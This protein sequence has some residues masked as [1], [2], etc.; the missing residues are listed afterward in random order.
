MN[1]VV[2]TSVFSTFTLWE[3]FSVFIFSFLRAHKNAKQTIF[4]LLEVFMRALLVCF[5][6][7]R[8]FVLCAPEIFL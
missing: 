3:L 5:G 7:R 8:V 1:R 6:L 2:G 4:I